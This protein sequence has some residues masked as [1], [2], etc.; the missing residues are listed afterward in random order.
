MF[1]AYKTSITD[2]GFRM[3]PCDMCGKPKR[4]WHLITSRWSKLHASYLNRNDDIGYVP[5]YLCSKKCVT[6]AVIYNSNIVADNV[7]K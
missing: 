1:T 7:N 6:F 4:L 5:L 2:N 3:S